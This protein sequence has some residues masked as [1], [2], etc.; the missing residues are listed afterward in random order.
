MSL[1]AFPTSHT[2]ISTGAGHT[3]SD[4]LRGPLAFSLLGAALARIVFDPIE[5]G[6]AI[7]LIGDLPAL[8]ACGVVIVRLEVQ[9]PGQRRGG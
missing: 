8:C 6:L 5:T 7:V 3:R 4:Y 9:T 1:M 2:K